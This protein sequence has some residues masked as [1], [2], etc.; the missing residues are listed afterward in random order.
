MTDYFVHES[1]YVDDG[2]RIG[3]G[4]GARHGSAAKRMAG[5]AQT[6]MATGYCQPAYLVNLTFEYRILSYS[7]RSIDGR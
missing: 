7:D 2:A 6:V 4:S 3:A 5:L 1:A